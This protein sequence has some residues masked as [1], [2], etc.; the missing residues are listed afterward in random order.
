MDAEADGENESDNDDF[1]E[2]L[3]SSKR[4]AAKKTGANSGTIATFS[5]GTLG[6]I[7]M[8]FLSFEKGIPSTAK[9]TQSAGMQYVCL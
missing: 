3:D 2:E 6:S 5:G 4:A 8:C 7:R 1:W 9:P